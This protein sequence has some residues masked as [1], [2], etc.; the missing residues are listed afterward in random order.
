MTYTPKQQREN[1]KKWVKALRSGKYAQCQN[2]LQGGKGFCCLGVLA[3]VSGEKYHGFSSNLAYLP[4]V[5]DFVG[6]SEPS[7]GFKQGQGV[8]PPQLT[9]LNDM[10]KSFQEIADIIESEP[11]GLFTS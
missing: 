9:N 11:E 8:H 5:M 6:L 10:G 7:G 4:K 3:E 2:Y 1:R